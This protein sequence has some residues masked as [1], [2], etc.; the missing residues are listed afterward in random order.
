MSVQGIP[1]R[2]QMHTPTFRLD[3]VFPFHFG[4]RVMD[5]RLIM[6]K[7]SLSVKVYCLPISFRSNREELMS[8]LYLGFPQLMQI[9]ERLVLINSNGTF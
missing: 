8:K 9:T 6:L 2:A 1:S 4:S 7:F 3:L 5:R